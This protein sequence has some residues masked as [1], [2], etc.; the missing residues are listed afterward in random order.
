MIMRPAFVARFYPSGPWRIGADSGGPE[1]ASS[2]LHSDAVY[3][4]VSWAMERLGAL[5][6]WI[7]GVFGDPGGPPVRFSSCFPFLDGVRLVAPPAHLW[8]PPPS[9]KIRWKGA[10]LVPWEAVETL[11]AGQALGEEEWRVDGQS[12]CLLPA[13]VSQGPFRFAVRS[14]CAMDRMGGGAAAKRLGCLEFAP[15]AGMWVLVSFAD[16]QARSRWEGLVRSALLLLG[17]SGVGGRRSAGWGGASRVE[18]EEA[19]WPSFAA[20]EAPQ[21]EVPETGWWMLSTYIPAERDSVD[22]AKGRYHV[23]ERAGRVQEMAGGSLKRLSRMIGEGSVLVAP[24]AP[25]GEAVDLAPEG[26]PHPVYRAGFALAVQIP[27]REAAR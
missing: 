13:A 24:Q 25:R 20:A 8:P 26:V 10:R 18:F 11:V 15:G 7:E 12:Q 17:D 4:A 21:E 14:L 9:V 6:E 2:I 1:T 5:P 19:A 23:L 16:E 3:S 27:V 22:W